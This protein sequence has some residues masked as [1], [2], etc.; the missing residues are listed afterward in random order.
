MRRGFCPGWPVRVSRDHTRPDRLNRVLVKSACLLCCCWWRGA[1]DGVGWGRLA[2]RWARWL[3]GRPLAR[4]SPLLESPREKKS[5]LGLPKP[6]MPRPHAGA[7][8][9]AAPVRP[10]VPPSSSTS[11]P[12]ADGGWK[13]NC[14]ENRWKK[15]TT[16][17][18]GRCSLSPLPA[19]GP[20][21]TASTLSH[22]MARLELSFGDPLLGSSNTTRKPPPASVFRGLPCFSVRRDRLAPTVL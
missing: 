22:G 15:N 3:A 11:N 7:S 12:G 10:S 8:L 18:R 5:Q 17:F 20:H 16:R 21:V 4:W 9:F 2:T 6:P 1:C 19:H 13:R 14:V